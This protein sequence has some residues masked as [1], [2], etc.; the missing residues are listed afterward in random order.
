MKTSEPIQTPAAPAG[1]EIHL[2]GPSALPLVSA[3]G[4]TLIVIG[5][6]LSLIIA[7][8]GAVILVACLARWIADSRRSLSELPEFHE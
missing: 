3:I 4:I 8:I 5:L 6:G 1:E 2:S 7:A